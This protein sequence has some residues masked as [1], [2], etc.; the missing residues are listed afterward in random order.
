MSYAHQLVDQI[1]MLH[2]E[3][4]GGWHDRELDNPYGGILATVCEQ[5]QYNYL[6]W[7]EE[8]IARSTD[9]GDRRIAEVKRAIDRYNQQRNDWIE[10]ID[11]RL[12]QELA[13]R[14][15]MPQTTARLNSETPG[16][17]IDRLSILALRIYHLEEQA[18]RNDA[19]QEHRAKVND[20]LA[21]CRDQLGDLSN[22]LAE[23]LV[24]VMTGQKVLKIYRQFKMYNDPTMNPYLYGAQKLAG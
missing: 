22:S 9:V 8:D 12:I 16:A 15:V 6:L 5:H 19:D 13:W 24:D 20:R 3:T 7:H 14:G 18:N 21:R 11:E 10:K 4:V 2:R 17:A 23:L 1:V